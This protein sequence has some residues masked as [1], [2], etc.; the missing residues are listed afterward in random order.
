MESLERICY[1]DMQAINTVFRDQKIGARVAQAGARVCGGSH[2]TY[3]LEIKRGVSIKDVMGVAAD[4]KHAVALGRGLRSIG[5]RLREDMVVEVPHP[6]PTA[7]D[8]S[9]AALE[10]APGTML[11]G[12]DYTDRPSV[13]SIVD[14]ERT[15]HV[16]VAGMSGSGKSTLVRSL[17]GTLA[18]NTSPSDLALYLVDLKGEDL[19]AFADL[20]HV[21]AAAIDGKDAPASKVVHTVDAIAN[22]RRRPGANV[23]GPQVV[24]F[25]DELSELPDFDTL[26]S[27]LRIGRSKRVHVVA[28]AQRPTMKL[29]GEKANYSTRLVGKVADNSEAYTA[30]GRKQSGAEMLPGR[31]AFLRVEDSELRRI[32][33]YNFNDAA[34]E[35]VVEAARCRWGTVTRSPVITGDQGAFAVENWPKMPE[36]A[37]SPVITGDRSPIYA[38][39]AVPQTQRSAAPAAPVW[40]IKGGREFTAAEAVAVRDM[41]ESSMSL[42]AIC[43]T[44]YGGAK[45]KERMDRI[46]R[47]VGVY[48]G[49]E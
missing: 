31:G 19:V 32:Q 47:A 7:L 6:H 39:V 44:V 12:R 34:V 30:T 35:A 23:N 43:E 2:I 15:A 40:P 16:L 1:R 27:I 9:R 4:V 8:Y 25:I 26:G 38:S 18:L 28:A 48:G 45:N 41:Y 36:N 11:A 20:P 42:T 37:R 17:L 49:A 24:L 5:L 13:D 46:K 21:V 3:E 22:E 33:V 29:I 10:M 14:F